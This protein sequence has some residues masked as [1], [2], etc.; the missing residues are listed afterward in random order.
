MSLPTALLVSRYRAFAAEEALPLRPLTLLYGRNNAGKSALA[1]ALGIVGA[2]VA[3]KVG[4]ALSYPPGV[5]R[6]VDVSE[7][8]WQ[9]EAGDYSMMLGLRWDEG[10]VREARFTLDGGPDRPA[11][12]KEL[13]ILGEGGK[14]LWSG[15]TPPERP[16]QPLPGQAGGEVVFD[17]LVPQDHEVSA[18]RV[19]GERL[20]ALRGKVRWL[21]GVRARPP[22][23]YIRRGPLPVH[24]GD[25][26][27]A[28][29]RLVA[30]PELV[31]E[32]NRFYTELDP[33]RELQVKEELD[34]GYRIRL[35]PASR[36]SFRIDL[37]DTGEGMVQVLP[38]LVAG[39]LAA[40]EGAGAILSIEEPESHLHPDAQSKLAQRFCEI[41]RRD[42]PPYV[43]LETHSRIFLLAVQLEIAKGTLPADRVGLAWI[44]QDA[45]G[46]SHVTPVELSPSGHPRAGWPAVA[47]GED[48]RLAGELARR[49]LPKSRSEGGS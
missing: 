34:A 24:A 29:A 43:V 2:S 1:R 18:I 3:E 20:R 8:A 41:A 16:M 39:A 32:V 14:L 48:L 45:Q 27:D 25:G 44:D 21:D 22:R 26:S 37:A 11:Y 31:V 4:A 5:P 47:L 38:V 33:P 36:P 12:A 35:S 42:Q 10:E 6:V 46:C 15:I 17:G 7:L 9:G 23:G 13:E 40:R 19:L 49:S 30:D 28:Y